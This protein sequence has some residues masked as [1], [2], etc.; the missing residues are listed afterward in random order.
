MEDFLRVFF[1]FKTD[2]LIQQAIRNKF[3]ECTVL[4]MAHRLRT[5]IEYG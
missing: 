5:V 1:L 4:T 2:E 3:Q